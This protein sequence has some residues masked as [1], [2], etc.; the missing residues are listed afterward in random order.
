[1]STPYDD[2]STWFQGAPGASV[3]TRARGAWVEPPTG[4]P[5]SRF[6]VF[7]FQGGPKPDV[8]MISP[9]VDV[10]ILG[11]RGE[12]NLA[13]SLPDMENFVYDLVARSMSSTCSGKI[14]GIRAIGLPVGPGFTEEDRPWY[15]ISFELTGVALS[16]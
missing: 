2:F 11:K 10:T 14:T 9:V 7:Q 4:T 6:A 12:R 16:G 3:Y 13:G 1:M 8:D 15:K 5:D